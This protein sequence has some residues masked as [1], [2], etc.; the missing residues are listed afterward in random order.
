[1][2]A[3]APPHPPRLS[4]AQP[5][6]APYT[7][8]PWSRQCPPRGLPPPAR[9]ACLMSHCVSRTVPAFSSGTASASLGW[10]G[11]GSRSVH[12]LSSQED[13][14]AGASPCPARNGK[15]EA[16]G[17]P[18][19]GSRRGLRWP[20]PRPGGL[21]SPPGLHGDHPQDPVAPYRKSWSSPWPGQQQHGGLRGLSQSEWG[22]RVVSRALGPGNFSPP[23][24]K[25][26][27][28]QSLG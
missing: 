27:T 24:R 1:M 5:M 19:G 12:P 17:T 9:Q 7:S 18:P 2:P 13:P 25:E 21:A 11:T 4:L 3:N 20:A 28:M 10:P 23:Q 14:G 8:G 26:P 16:R 6:P 15:R 22:G